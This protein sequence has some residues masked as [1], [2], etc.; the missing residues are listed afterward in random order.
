MAFLL[1]PLPT[2]A[3]A[4][5]VLIL[6]YLLYRAAL[7]RPIPGIPYHKASANSI[8]GDIPAMMKH[9][10]KTGQV[11]D[12]MVA[13][14]VELNSPIVQ[15]FVRPLGRPFVV[16]ADFRE[17]QDVLMR[18]MGEFD[19]SDF[20]G[21]LFTGVIPDHH[22]VMK[23]TEKF[24][25]QRRLLADTM[26]PTFLHE[27]LAPQIYATAT[28]LIDLWRLKSTL[29]QGH[30]WHA[31]R[32]IYHAA[33]DAIWSA[34]F[35]SHPG[36]TRSQLELLSTIE[37]V[38]QP[39]S[40]DS[41]VEFPKAATPPAFDAV[42]TLCDSMETTIK[43]PMPTLHHW[44]LRQLPYMRSAKAYK[45]QYITDQLEQARQK[46]SKAS[47]KD[48]SVNSAIEHLLRRELAA[49]EKEGRAPE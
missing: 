35:H 11:F 17:N 26:S 3:A 23:T 21:D 38:E 19:R 48:R 29:A 44:V 30:P 7:P 43:S 36:T 42:I 6:C 32:D 10:N 41:P 46:F 34:V 18:R 16:M 15:V 12:W 37:K 5:A 39:K 31:P 1:L 4:G 45:D 20:F 25:Q 13:Q 47:E 27:V 28:D 9:T 40:R 14:C 24:K 33:L 8:L 22:I 2:V 49:A